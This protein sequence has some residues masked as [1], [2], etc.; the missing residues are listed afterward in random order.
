MAAETGGSSVFGTRV[1]NIQTGV[2]VADGAITGT[3]KYLDTGAIPDQWGAGN[4]LVLKF[5]DI[6]ADAPS[7]KVG[8]S[9]SVSSGL[10]ELID[11]PD[12]NGVFKVTDKDTQKFVVIQ[13]N[14]K[15]FSRQEYSLSGLTCQTE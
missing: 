6:D 10:V 8:L 3:L 15:T 7:V 1:S 5:S 13:S 2:T 9:P 14:G 4:F 11:D 12:K